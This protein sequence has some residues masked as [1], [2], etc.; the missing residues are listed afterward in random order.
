MGIFH[1]FV[2][3]VAVVCVVFGPSSTSVALRGVGKF[4]NFV[5]AAAVICVMFGPMVQHTQLWASAERE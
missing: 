1:K 2:V 5:A 4:H 3:A